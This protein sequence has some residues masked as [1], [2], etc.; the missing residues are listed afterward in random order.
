M[1][2]QENPLGD[3]LEQVPALLN[4]RQPVLAAGPDHILNGCGVPGEA[5]TQY[6]ESLLVEVFTQITHYLRCGGETVHQQAAGGPAWEEEGFGFWDDKLFFHSK[7]AI[8]F[9]AV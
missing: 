9:P 8:P 7:E 6:G 2:H 4:R 5:Y 3:V 1:P